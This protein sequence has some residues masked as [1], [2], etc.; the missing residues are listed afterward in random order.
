MTKI[1][2]V[3]GWQTVVTHHPPEYEALAAEH[4]QVETKFGNAKIRDA[5]T[6]LRFILLHVGAD[7]PLRQTVAVMAEAN[8]PRLSPMCLHKKMIRAAPYLRALVERMVER[9]SEG[10][11]QLWTGYLFETDVSTGG[12]AP[13]AP[14]A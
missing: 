9:P 2:I 12:F 1:D 3:D 4:Q 14:C 10:A 7:L 8:A 11:P 13:G 5:S 6:L